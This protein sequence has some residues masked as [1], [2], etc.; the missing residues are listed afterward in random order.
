VD[1]AD[2]PHL[3]AT[4][5]SELIRKREVSPVD[6]VEAYLERIDLLND[7]LNAYITVCHGEA[8]EAARQ[9]EQA[10]ALGNY[11]G[12]MHGVPVTVKDQAHTKGIRTTFGSPI[13]ADFVPDED[14]TVISKLKASGAILLGKSNMTEFGTT[15]F[16][17]QF[18]TPRNPWDL[19]RYTG[20]SSSG[21]GAA[22][23]GFLC[24]TSLGEDTGGSIRGPAAWCG[25]VGLRPS[26]G[27]V[28]RYGVRPGS[29]TM[30]TMGPISRTVAD[31]ALT[32]Q[33]IAGHDPKDPFTWQCPVPD[34]L[35]ALD[36][37]IRGLKVGII[38]DLL[39]SE[40]VDREVRDAVVQAKSVLGELE[41]EVEDVSIPLA[42][43]AQTI[44]SA[45]RVEA[46]VTYG[47][48]LRNRLQEIGHDNRISYLVGSVLPAQAYY[49]AQKLRVMLRQQVLAALERFD[50]LVL[51][52]SA[53][54][55][56]KVEPDPVIDSKEKAFRNSASLTPIF[57]LASTPALSINCGF[58]SQGLPIG[59]QIGGR[60]FDEE[61][62]LKVA[63]AYEQ[64][65]PW[66][67]RKPPL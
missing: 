13:F 49:K 26:W 24:A 38:T 66:H 53:S 29:W 17:H 28:S 4:E 42:V 58:N 12:P 7:K 40:R 47:E 2:I 46:P 21:S 15:G 36:G 48:L 43:H 50:V 27:R 6:V 65:T 32:I 22:T 52:T 14:A 9:A 61:T 51:P 25:L 37:D 10:I 19:E 11:L 41:A 39:Y 31:C 64:S 34:Y 67:N 60:I 1:K 45:L 30:D 44:S 20:G 62:V 16:S 33:T 59:L 57:S 3:S 8:L 63:Y 54:V 23:A 18:D 35:R 5:L 55:A 56:P